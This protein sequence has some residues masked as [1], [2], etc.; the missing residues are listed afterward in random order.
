M[1][2][3][4]MC[5]FFR[6]YLF[7]C[8][9]VY[10]FLPGICVC[11]PK[12]VSRNDFRGAQGVH[13]QTTVACSSWKSKSQVSHAC[14]CHCR[15]LDKA[16]RR[17]R[18]SLTHPVQG[19]CSHTRVVHH[20]LSGTVRFDSCMEGCHSVCLLVLAVSQICLQTY[21]FQPCAYS[22][23]IYIYIY[24]YMYVYTHTYIIHTH[25]LVGHQ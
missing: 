15:C 10:R 17:D 19:V 11:A 1:Y 4:V 24:M 9:Y 5:V 13:F 2:C 25:M 18:I 22:L 6:E 21:G 12:S 16:S 23:Y 7:Y 20:C 14:A 3:F 8:F